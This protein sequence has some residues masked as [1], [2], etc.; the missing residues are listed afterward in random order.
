MGLFSNCFR[1]SA[2]GTLRYPLKKAFEIIGIGCCVY[3]LNTNTIENP[4]LSQESQG[5]SQ[6]GRL[7]LGHITS[8]RNEK[9]LLGYKLTI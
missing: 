1:L 2:K 6:S 8:E 4:M 9:V 3:S 5:I 7:C